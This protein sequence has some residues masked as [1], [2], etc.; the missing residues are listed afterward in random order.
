M[1]GWIRLLYPPLRLIK[2]PLKE[3]VDSDDFFIDFSKAPEGFE[4]MYID[5]MFP[6]DETLERCAIM[7]DFGDKTADLKEMWANAK[8]S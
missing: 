7:R 2:Q 5:M 4:D 8:A 6:S 1:F 3:Y